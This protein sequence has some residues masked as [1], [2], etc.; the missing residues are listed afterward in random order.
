MSHA[1][2]WVP[3][4]PKLQQVQERARAHR[5][6]RFTSLAHLIT[7]EALRRAYGRLRASAKPG[8][9]R[10]TKASYGEGLDARLSELHERLRTGKYRS[11]PAIRATT[12]KADGS[13]RELSVWCVEDKVVQ[14]AVIEVLNSIFETDFLPLSYGFRPQRSPHQALQAVQ[15]ALQ[16]GRVNWILDLDLAKCFDR[17]EHEALRQALDRR[18][19]DRS[20][21]KLI[22]K[23]L[24][25]GV[26]DADGRRSRQ[27]RGVP[28]GAP[29]SP[30]L[31]NI[32]LHEAMDQ[33]LVKRRRQ[34]QGEVY[35]VRYADDAVLMFE[36]ET[37]A[38]AIWEELSDQL[39]R[40]GLEMN[41]AKT[42]LVPFGRTPPGGRSGTIDFLGFTH[43]AGK[44]R[45]GRYLV[46]RKTARKRMARSL[47]K[48]RQWCRQHMHAPVVEQWRTLSMKLHGHYEY[49][50]IR[51]NMRALQRMRTQVWWIWLRALRRR[52]QNSRIDR[53]VALLQTRFRLPDPR[54]THP[55]DW[56][57]VS[58]GYLLG[59]AGCGK[60]ARPVL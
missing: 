25:V 18:V 33:W 19:T 37:D 49:Y 58:P 7:P 54:I 50:G 10:H 5:E 46:K 27:D 39:A 45:Q 22:G 14:G 23:W 21:L 47:T 12:R 11:Q 1:P 55:D 3:I 36:H 56:L 4:C 35:M 48:V 53:L 59:R 51:G 57:P 16:K 43:M 9:D 13:D 52:S 15:T 6:E 34:A 29:I 31:A 28:Q 44:D 24:T 20:V 38:H 26:V 30:V 40:Y 60:A 32:V 2:K 41:Q 17:I 42:K 8:V